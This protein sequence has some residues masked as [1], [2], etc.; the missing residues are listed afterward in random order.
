VSLNHPTDLL[1]D[2][3]NSLLIMAWHNHKIRRWDPATGLSTV[4]AGRGPGFVDGP[5]AMARLRQPS[6]FTRDAAGNFYI[7]DQANLRVR[8]VTPDFSTM[9]TIAGVG[10]R[11]FS[12]D[13]GDPLMAQFSVQGGENPEPGGDVAIAGSRLFIADSENNRIRMIDLSATPQTIVTVVGTGTVGTA[14]DG[15]PGASAQLTSPRDLEIGP[16]GAL[17][18]ADTGN[19]AIRRIDISSPMFTITTVAGTLG[20]PGVA[21][22]R[23]PATSARLARPFGLAFDAA[24]NLFIADTLN[25]RIRRVE[26]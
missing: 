3:D 23:G 15:G 4:I 22:E 26:H 19:H 9:S 5:M 1:F 24:G 8:M 13:G 2:T 18:V 25:N 14:G 11:G 17:Y 12:G 21:G 6:K 7:F 20:E 10:T 16:D